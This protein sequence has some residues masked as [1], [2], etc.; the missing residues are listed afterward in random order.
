MDRVS[1][2]PLLREAW[3]AYQR[4]NAQWL[5]AAL[6]YF[7]A[8]AVAPL[9]IVVVAIAGFFLH[10]HQNVLDAI[11]T[12]IPGSGSG[13]V[14]Q[15]VEATLA[16]PRHTLTAQVASWGLFGFAALGLFS[17]LQFAL[18]TAWDVTPKKFGFWQAIRERA[19]AFA[20]MLAVAALL[21]LSVIANTLLVAATGYL[22][23]RTAGLSTL[24][25]V[26]DF[27][28]TFA[29]AWL[30][31]AVLFEYLPET[32]IAW[33]D[34]WLGA[35]LTALLFVIGQSILGWYLGRAGIGS[36]YGAFGSLVLFLIWANYSAQIV[37]FGAEFTHVYA[38]RRGSRQAS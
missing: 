28:L 15:M 26:S 11:Y 34:V 23:Q 13:A 12:H 14:A 3:A 16:Q 4:H 8:F 17:S 7:A 2:V 32:R 18:N 35:G 9:I 36:A 30:L 33:R 6:A 37:L 19:F 21:L 24:M 38:L 31:F 29:V 22:G 10:S 27:T 20:M 25:N 1:W 5:A